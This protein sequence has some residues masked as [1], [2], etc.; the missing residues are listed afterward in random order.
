MKILI[1]TTLTP[2]HE[3]FINALK[4]YR[5]F[6]YSENINTPKCWRIMEQAEIVMVY[7]T[8]KLTEETI[9]KNNIILNFHGGNPEYYRGLD[10]HLWAIYHNDWNLQ[11]T[12]HHVEPTLD[13]GDIVFQTGLAGF[14]SWEELEEV[15][16][17]AAIDMAL[18]TLSSKWLPRRKQA[19][20]GRYYGAMPEPLRS[21]TIEKISKVF[22]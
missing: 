15:N 22:E 9:S 10:S 1:L 8:G 11:A 19:K 14:K 3:E 16:N 20:R 2:H 7:G 18:L 6:L 12:M 5:P 17:Q 21:K 4:E 13:T